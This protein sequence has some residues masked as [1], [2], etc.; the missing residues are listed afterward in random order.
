M[1]Y[2]A[3]EGELVFFLVLLSINNPKKD[4]HA[5]SHTTYFS[6]T[7]Y[8][9]NRC[10]SECFYYSVRICMQAFFFLIEAEAR[11]RFLKK[12]VQDAFVSI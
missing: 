6:K 7:S 8:E 3:V 12:H 10:E 11:F 4:V 5:I 1:V 9:V 2:V